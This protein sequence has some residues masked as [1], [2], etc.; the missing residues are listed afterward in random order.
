MSSVTRHQMKRK[1]MKI[2]AIKFHTYCNDTDTKT[3]M[4]LTHVLL[5]D[6]RRMKLM[7]QFGFNDN[8]ATTDNFATAT[9]IKEQTSHCVDEL[10][11][12]TPN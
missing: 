8:H 6:D 7:E 10:N 9:N 5:E 1:I 4:R 3:D 11:R 2:N 12:N